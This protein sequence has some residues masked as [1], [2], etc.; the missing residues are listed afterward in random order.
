MTTEQNAAKYAD[1]VSTK[2]VGKYDNIEDWVTALVKGNASI[3]GVK[4]TIIYYANNYA[5][6]MVNAFAK[7]TQ[8]QNVRDLYHILRR[9]EDVKL[10][11][12]VVVFSVDIRYIPSLIY[13]WRKFYEDRGFEVK[14]DQKPLIITTTLEEL[15]KY[16]IS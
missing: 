10:A 12:G 8:T 2:I 4:D 11:N 15:E 14:L 1:K 5:E 7:I 9:C 13:K 6:F 3:I 16:E